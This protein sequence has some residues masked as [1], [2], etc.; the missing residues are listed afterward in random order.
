MK[1]CG[2]CGLELARESFSKKQWQLNQKRRCKECVGNGVPISE[3]ATPTLSNA[4]T[5]GAQAEDG[6]GDSNA[7]MVTGDNTDQDEEEIC[8]ICLEVYD[9]PKRLPCGHSFCS[10]C[11]DGWHGPLKYGAAHLGKRTCPICRQRTLPSNEILS[12]LHTFNRCVEDGDESMESMKK[13]IDE[14]LK[15]LVDMGYSVEEIN[16]MVDEYIQSQEWLPTFLFDAFER[17]EFQPVLDWLGSPIDKRKLNSKSAEMAQ[18]TLLHAT[19]VTDLATRHS[20][21]K[22]F[23]A[24][25]LQ[26]GATV[27]AYDAMGYTP[28]H[29]RLINTTDEEHDNMHMDKV[30][31]LLYEWGASAKEQGLRGTALGP[32]ARNVPLIQSEY[33]GRRCE[34]VN[35]NQRKDL[36]GQTCV[37]EKFIARKN[38]YKVTTEHTHET[39]LV[40]PDNL[41]RRDRTPE[42]PG[43]YVT[44]EGGEFERH[45]FASNEE[46]QEFV[47]SLEPDGIEP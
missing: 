39:F 1:I 26:S 16:D 44:F 31:K 41:K 7:D 9:D 3:A 5:G 28:F 17:G 6:A 40:G 15:I 13:K 19:V 36:I 35:L 29:Q 25:L 18:F 46:C 34:L 32:V 8:G 20:E 33:G 14:D 24:L 27:D 22:D 2:A 21:R 38:R 43:Y 11:L 42:D 30:A 10:S 47:R 23:T 37:V 12:Q 45:T 4:A